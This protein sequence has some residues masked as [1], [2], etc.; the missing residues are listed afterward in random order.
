[1][2]S[3]HNS[4]SILEEH[5]FCILLIKN[6]IFYNI[7]CIIFQNI[8]VHHPQLYRS[9]KSHG[10]FHNMPFFLCVQQL[11]PLTDCKSSDT[12]Q[13]PFFGLSFGLF[14]PGLLWNILLGILFLS[15]LKVTCPL[16]SYY[17]NLTQYFFFF[18]EMLQFITSLYSLHSILHNQ[19][20]YF[21]QDYSLLFSFLVVRAFQN[22]SNNRF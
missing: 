9:W 11:Y 21:S 3:T 2:F 15:Y 12:V 7:Y 13:P 10:L 8:Y 17:F 14:P 18:T 16:Y 4:F 6:C 5:M 1:M 19:S 20:I 22:N